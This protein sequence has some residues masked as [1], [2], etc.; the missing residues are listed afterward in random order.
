MALFT[1]TRGLER[2]FGPEGAAECRFSALFGEFGKYGKNRKRGVL[3]SSCLLSSWAEWNS[4]RCGFSSSAESSKIKI[5]TSSWH[6]A[7]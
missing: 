2:L 6:K 1:T 7:Y 5:R 4:G 3:A